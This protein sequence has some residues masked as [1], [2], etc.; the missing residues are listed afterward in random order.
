MLIDYII[1]S[2]ARAA[3]RWLKS[4]TNIKTGLTEEQ[5]REGT[6]LDVDLK[7]IERSWREYPW[8]FLAA[9]F[10]GTLYNRVVHHAAEPIR[11]EDLKTTL[12]SVSVGWVALHA[13]GL[14]V[15]VRTIS[16]RGSIVDRLRES[17]DVELKARAREL[18][19][20]GVNY[21]REALGKMELRVVNADA[22]VLRS[23]DLVE[24]IID[25]QFL[26][27]VQ[28]RG[29]GVYAFAD[30]ETGDERLIRVESGKSI[31]GQVKRVVVAGKGAAS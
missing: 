2:K 26:V 27:F 24:A 9:C 7:R 21:I 19:A 30:A 10:F 4:T 6:A 25:G 20:E 17:A 1:G 22:L 16:L 28:P 13:I 31:W 12:I 5:S 23:G 15:F 8:V 11:G 14:F 18:A 3:A 29:D